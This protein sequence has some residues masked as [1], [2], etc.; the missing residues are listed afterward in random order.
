MALEETR[1]EEILLMSWISCALCSVLLLAGVAASAAVMPLEKPSMAVIVE[2]GT[3]TVRGHAV[4]VASTVQLAVEPRS[5]VHVKAEEHILTE[6]DTG[7][8]AGATSLNKVL[9]PVDTGTRLPNVLDADSVVVYSGA[10][11]DTV[12]VV[13]KDYKLDRVWGGLARVDG[14]AMPKGAKVLVDYTVCLQRIDTVQVS[15]NG[16]AS[17]KKGTSAAVCAPDTEPDPGCTPLANVYVCYQT[18]AVTSSDIYPLSKQHLSWR[19]FVKTSGKEN[20]A[21]TL[22][23]LKAG[24]PVTVVCWG[25]SV[26]A[27]G[28]ASS[29]DKCYVELFRARLKAAYPKSKI[30][31]INA[32]IG[33]SNTNSRH[34]GYD[35]EVLSYNPDL[36]TVEFVNDIGMGPDTIKKN[37]AEFVSRARQKNPSVEFILI[38]PHNVMPEWMTGFAKSADA[39]RQAAVD[40]NVA[41]ADAN[42]VWMNLRTV[43][44]PYLSLLANGINHP[45]DLGHDVFAV[46]IME[47][48]N[49][50]K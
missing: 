38:T 44:I 8:W 11:R 6:G 16:V 12:Y 29:P 14:G 9:G 40:N 47:L 41:L 27:G 33:G 5:A 37:W 26:T 24:S 3:Y 22:G 34:D 45:N 48:M 39:M 7:T 30:T 21:H 25:D 17:I 42:N 4:K 23:L 31:L 28:S 50:E 1:N 19:D 35:K 10:A 36:I 49:P 15:K 2:A 43:G 32:G 13:D 20:L 18:S 46:S